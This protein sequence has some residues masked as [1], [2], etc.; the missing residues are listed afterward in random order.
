M[1]QGVEG[2]AQGAEGMA[3]GAEGIELRID[4]SRDP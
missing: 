3:Q 2:M 1:A 4:D